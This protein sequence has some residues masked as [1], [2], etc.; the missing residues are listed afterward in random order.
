LRSPDLVVPVG[1]LPHVQFATLKV[2]VFP[3]KAAQF[4]SPQPGKDD[5]YQQRAPFA[6]RGINQ[7]LNFIRGRDVDPRFQLSLGAPVRSDG[8]AKSYVL[9]NVATSLRLT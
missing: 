9:R 1:T 4:G 5:R 7:P 2:Y 3:T 8:N 6:G